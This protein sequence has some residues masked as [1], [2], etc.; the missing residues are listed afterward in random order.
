MLSNEPYQ[1]VLQGQVNFQGFLAGLYICYPQFADQ[2]D[3]SAFI[4]GPDPE[5]P[6]KQ[7]LTWLS[8]SI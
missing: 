7:D 1:L 8:A 5:Q 3:P 6:G 2:F 4:L